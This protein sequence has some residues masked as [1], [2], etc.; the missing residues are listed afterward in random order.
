MRTPTINRRGFIV[1][2]A[3]T[4]AASAA[5]LY[6][7]ERGQGM[8]AYEQ[9]AEA[10]RAPLSAT[11]DQKDL[12]RYA[13]LSA[14]SHNTQPWKFHLAPN[15]IDILPDFSRRTPV[16]DPDDHHLFTT[17]GCATENLA[18][19]AAA[20]GLQSQRRAS[21]RP[22]TGPSRCRSSRPRRSSPPPSPRS[23]QGR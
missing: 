2:A 5:A 18:I 20:R 11:P 1:G 6:V 8:N 15:R 19:A 17:L 16:V 23:R 7:Y 14:N 3:A 10:I 4:G 22:A 21:I 12:V 13:T 9:T